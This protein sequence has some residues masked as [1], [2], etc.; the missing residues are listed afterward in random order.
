MKIK[1]LSVIALLMLIA[2]MSA[3]AEKTIAQEWVGY[4]T[5]GAT[6]P[7]SGSTQTVPS[8]KLGEFIPEIT[9][10]SPTRSR[11]GEHLRLWEVER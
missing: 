9:G 2:Y 11:N 5:P 1:I 4:A 10:M 8:D 6:M 7:E 3:G